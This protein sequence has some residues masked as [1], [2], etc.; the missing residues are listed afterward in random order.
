MF[1]TPS[2]LGSHTILPAEGVTL[3][4]SEA[5]DEAVQMSAVAR[6]LRAPVFSSP[7]AVLDRVLHLRGWDA[8]LDLVGVVSKLSVLTVQAA[9][10][11]SLAVLV[12]LLG[13]TPLDGASHADLVP[14]V[15]GV[16]RLAFEAVVVRA[17]DVERASVVQEASTALAGG[18]VGLPLVA[19]LTGEGDVVARWL[20]LEGVAAFSELGV[21]GAQEAEDYQEWCDVEGSHCGLDWV[22]ITFLYLWILSWVI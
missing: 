7:E 1:Q 2:K 20:W 18:V 10:A 19:E 16:P 11:A 17:A 14:G 6:A 9:E 15:Q 8:A 21:R 22:V 3:V 13:H 5:R 12:D 4:T